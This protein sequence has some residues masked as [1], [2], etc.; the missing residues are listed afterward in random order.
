[1][2]A[3]ANAPGLRF[4]TSFGYLKS[5]GNEAAQWLAHFESAGAH[6]AAELSRALV[7]LQKHDIQGGSLL[8]DSLQRDLDFL[9][10]EHPSIAH[11]L[12]RWYFTAEAYRR[13]LHEDFDGARQALGRA[14]EEILHVLMAHPFMIP[15]AV[16]CTDFRIQA[17]RIARRQNRWLEV[18]NWMEEIRQTYADQHPFCVLT[19][20]EKVCMS[21]VR[22][23]Y[24]TLDLDEEERRNAQ[25][26]LD[27][28][29]PHREWIDRLEESIFVLTDF[30]ISYR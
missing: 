6:L 1:V 21:T 27:E 17:A 30:V 20:G 19:T 22:S 3:T 10:Y 24:R 2:S 12:R 16:H 8:L 23:F 5:C 25:F 4:V 28:R 18:R 14:R 29:F 26:A 7:S 15:M 9:S 11:V 13:Y